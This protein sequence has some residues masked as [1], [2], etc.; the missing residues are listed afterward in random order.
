[1]HFMRFYIALFFIFLIACPTAAMANDNPIEVVAD[2]ALEW[3][4]ANQKVTATG[5]AIVT[6]GDSNIQ[7]PIITANYSE[8]GNDMTIQSVIA[9]PNA[10]LT[11]PSEV[12][13]AN[14]LRADFD[15]GILSSVT[16][17]ENV[18]LKTANEVLYGDRGVYD[19]QRRI[20]TVTG[21]V[22]IEQDNNVL[23]GTKAEFDLNTNISRLSNDK[24]SN[25]G[26][27]RAVFGGGGQ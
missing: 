13:S 16:A 7:A 3:D 12:L 8:N 15:N 1:M 6:Q 5:N 10:V 9:Q 25:D 21:N 4:R 19:A 2:E 18:V 17:T 27:V 20:I 11:R 23:T 24:T 22:R 26:R 14:S